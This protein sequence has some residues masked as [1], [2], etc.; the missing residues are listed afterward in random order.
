MHNVVQGNQAPRHSSVHFYY[1]PSTNAANDIAVWYNEV[2]VT[3]RS[4]DSFFSVNG[5]AYGYFGIQSVDLAANGAMSAGKV[6]FSIWD[7]LCK[8]DDMNA[9]PEDKRVVVEM[10]CSAC[11][12]QRFGDE[13]TGAKAYFVNNVWKLGTAYS[14]LTTAEAA[15]GNKVRFTG[16]FYDPS[17]ATWQIVGRILTNRGSKDWAL[18]GTFSFVEQWTHE[19]PEGVRWAKFGPILARRGWSPT[20]VWDPVYE[21]RWF[22]GTVTTEDQTHINSNKSA[23]L[24]EMGIGGDIVK[25]ANKDTYMTV[26]PRTTCPSPLIQWV[27]AEASSSLPVAAPRMSVTCGAHSRDNCSM[28]VFNDAGVDQGQSWCNG[29]C[30]WSGGS[31]VPVSA[32]RLTVP[33]ATPVI[34]H[35]GGLGTTTPHPS[36][37]VSTQRRLVTLELTIQNINYA[38]VVADAT[39]QSAFETAAKAAIASAAG[40]GVTS[41]HVAVTLSAGSVKINAKV[42]PPGSRN[43][44]S[45]QL[46]LTNVSSTAL[47]T[48][49]IA[50]I[51]KIANIATVSS[52][53]LSATVGTIS[54]E[55]VP[56]NMYTS[57]RFFLLGSQASRHATSFSLV[58]FLGW[59]ALMSSSSQ[60][61]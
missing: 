37:F 59:A 41:E 61:V 44:T 40:G 9:C 10:C 34:C 24:W 39:L 8:G 53:T 45:V 48:T 29:E 42:T 38:Q 30:T 28:C 32:R 19:K 5:H 58:L 14:F 23:D 47:P 1:Q 54:S 50:A 18:H 6:I 55:I 7:Q 11:V 25:I 2:T 35:D 27:S 60:P 3:A 26:T 31:C 52:G 56:S 36:G 12:C 57:R 21:A 16:Y 22:H 51:N 17:V 15:A 49:V 13:G 20:D 43:H 33:Q 46:S 4:E